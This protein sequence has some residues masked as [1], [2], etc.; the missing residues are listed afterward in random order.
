M[1]TGFI[2]RISTGVPGLDEMIEGGLPMPSLILIAGDIGSGKTT[3]CNQFLCKGAKLGECGLYFMTCGGPAE[4][5]I[6]FMSTYEFA[7][8]RYFGEIIR[9]I[10][11]D[12]II[13]EA[14]CAEDI[15]DEI[16][17]DLETSQ[18]RR[19]VIDRLS[20]IEEALK[21]DFRRFIPRLSIM[22][23]EH[24]AVALVTG[25]SMPGAPYSLETA[26][27]ADGIILLQN[28]EVNMARMRSIEVLKMCGTSH[29]LGK[30]AVDISV[31]GLT[32]YPG[33]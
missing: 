2:D 29:H 9:Y 13:D 33:L 8:R 22:V 17:S 27:V 14:C 26:Q 32:V 31:K 5:I 19:L 6:K 11:L 25:D 24:K 7:D 20:V 16:Q 3:L 23:K 4:W 21:E 10:N 18:P 30:R 28:S 12:K 1:S 15:L